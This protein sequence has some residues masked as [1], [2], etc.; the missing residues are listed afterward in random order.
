MDK[1]LEKDNLPRMNQEEIENMNRPVTTNEIEA[2]IKNLPT[3]KNP[4]SDGFRLQMESDEFYPMF[5]E[6]L[7]PILLK[8]F[9]KLQREESSETYSMRPPITLIPKSSQRKLQANITYEH[10]CKNPQQNASKQNPIT[11]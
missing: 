11:Y 3:N 4:G 1:F 9:Q 2:V 10:R 6:A 7:T 5:K 8:L